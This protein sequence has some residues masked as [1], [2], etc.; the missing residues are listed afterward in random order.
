VHYGCHVPLHA[1]YASH[2]WPPWS[3]WDHE[4]LLPCPFASSFMIMQ[5]MSSEVVHAGHHPTSDPKTPPSVTYILRLCR[6]HIMHS[7]LL[8]CMP[9][10]SRT[11]WGHGA[12]LVVPECS[13]IMDLMDCSQHLACLGDILLHEAPR[14]WCR[15]C[16]L[17]GS[18]DPK[19]WPKGMIA[20]CHPSWELRW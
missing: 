17:L 14:R 11:Y 5:L 8:C 15:S 16:P 2:S 6:H 12:H 3:F 4:C 7:L 10:L 18:Q 13:S 20:G 9:T 19:S 1:A